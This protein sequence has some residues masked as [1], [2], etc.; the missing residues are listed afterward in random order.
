MPQNLKGV[1]NLYTRVLAE[2]ESQPASERLLSQDRG[3][4]RTH[5][6]DHIDR[7][8]VPALLKHAHANHDPVGAVWGFELV[9]V[10][11]RLVRCIRVDGQY[12][13]R[14]VS[15]S[16]AGILNHGLKLVRFVDVL[17]N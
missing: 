2:R 1:Q 9:E 15:P 10:R 11:K 6:R 7:L 12:L 17:G 13:V 4:A 3:N 16:E 5:R 14:K 8:V